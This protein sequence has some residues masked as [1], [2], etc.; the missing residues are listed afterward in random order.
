M[1][2][3]MKE[4]TWKNVVRKNAQ[5]LITFFDRPKFGQLIL[6]PPSE[7]SNLVWWVYF[8]K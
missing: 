4:K 3:N 7:K 1:Y 2:Y 6:G 8:E 5:M